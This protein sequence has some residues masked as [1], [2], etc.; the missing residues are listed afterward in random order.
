MF[1]QV[2]FYQIYPSSGWLYLGLSKKLGINT[3]RFRWNRCQVISLLKNQQQQQERKKIFLVLL[4][5]EKK[6][7]EMETEEAVTHLQ[8]SLLEW[9]KNPPLPATLQSLRTSCLRVHQTELTSLVCDLS[10]TA[11]KTTCVKWYMNG[12]IHIKLE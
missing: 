5:A 12:S 6:S 8:R 10:A 2:F 11:N 7:T 4:F 1:K 3:A 9:F